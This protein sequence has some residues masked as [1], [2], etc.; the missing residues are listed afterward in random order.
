MAMMAMIERIMWLE[1]QHQLEPARGWDRVA[2][3]WWARMEREAAQCREHARRF[4]GFDSVSEAA[5]TASTAMAATAATTANESVARPGQTV[6]E[7]ERPRT[8]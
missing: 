7:W 6:T 8:S 4:T 2:A 1:R 5:S 3:G